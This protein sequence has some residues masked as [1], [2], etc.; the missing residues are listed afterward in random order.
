[1]ELLN[2]LLITGISFVNYLLN[3]VIYLKSGLTVPMEETDI[4][5]DKRNQKN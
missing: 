1:M 4:M 5:E 2:I 3:M